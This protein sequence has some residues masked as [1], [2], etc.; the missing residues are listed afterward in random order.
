MTAPYYTY[1]LWMLCS[2]CLLA[3]CYPGSKTAVPDRFV[4]QSETSNTVSESPNY[5]LPALLLM[6]D[7]EYVSNIK[8]VRLFQPGIEFSMPVIELG[9]NQKLQLLFDDLTGVY[10]E[11][12]YTIVHCDPFWN[13]SAMMPVDY[14]EGFSEGYVNGYGFSVASRQKYVH[15][16]TQIP[17]QD[18]KITRSGNYILIVYPAGNP[19]EVVFTRRFMVYESRVNVKARAKRTTT[20]EEIRTKQE[21]AFEI[22]KSMWQIDNPFTELVVVVQQNGR[23]D[24][25]LKGLMPRFVLGNTISY[26]WDRVVVFE[27]GNEFRHVDIRTFSRYTPRIAMIRSHGELFDVHVKPDYKRAYQV[28]IEDSDINGAYVINSDDAISNHN[29]EG[30]YAWVHFYLAAQ[31]PFDKGGVYLFGELTNW[32]LN[33]DFRMSYNEQNQTYEL[34]L[35]LKQGY[36]NYNYMLLENAA[37][38]ASASQTEGSHYATEN[39]YTI[40]VY[41]RKPGD[42]YDRLIA[43]ERVTAPPQQ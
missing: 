23:W 27:G 42:I 20:I 7:R 2:A 33:P 40:Y 19:N 8:S 6:E 32:Q 11:Y 1:L 10:Q 22:D 24:N 3:G 34:A 14:I 12:R 15:Y 36:Y 41:H 35:L 18:M 43:I 21:I 16:H 29:T 38:I 17:D 26:N 9:T 13:Q 4:E 39:L 30:D 25:A 37:D 28:Y 5:F 31:I